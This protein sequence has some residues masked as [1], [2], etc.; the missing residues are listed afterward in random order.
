MADG[1]VAKV[2]TM[3]VDDHGVV[4][5]V[6]M[7]IL[8]PKGDFA[9]VGEAASGEEAIAQVVA[10]RPRV[11][12][13]DVR[14]EEMS[15]IEACRAIKSAHPEV[16]VLMLTSYSEEEAVTA[17]IMAGASAYLLK[18]VGRSELIK[19][20]RGVAAGQNHLDPAGDGET[21]PAKR[22]GSGRTV[23]TRKGGYGLNRGGNH[24]SR[25]CRAIGYYRN[26]RTKPCKPHSG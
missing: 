17:A 2:R 23:P 6:L 25:Y 12:L 16:N 22:P 8:E 26:H 7:A 20:I 21:G 5:S 18:N 15:G 10:H 9:V 19:A 3:I 11:V 24:Q 4:R 13:M 14:M 1:K